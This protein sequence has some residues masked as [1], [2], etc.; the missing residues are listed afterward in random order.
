MQRERGVGQT[1]VGTKR[2]KEGKRLAKEY[3]FVSTRHNLTM[4]VLQSQA[5]GLPMHLKVNSRPA[6][7]TSTNRMVSFAVATSST[8][9][10]Q[11]QNVCARECACV[12]VCAR[13]RACVN[14][15]ERTR[16]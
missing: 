9:N 12:R 11:N 8:W 15:H 10:H 13:M 2:E 3:R 1:V 6:A 16:V 5:V 4:W 7:S 14:V